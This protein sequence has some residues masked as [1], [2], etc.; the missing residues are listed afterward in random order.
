MPTTL[1]QEWEDFEADFGDEHEGLHI[2]APEGPDWEQDVDTG[3][4][5]NDYK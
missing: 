4:M 3:P 1:L 2:G 5:I